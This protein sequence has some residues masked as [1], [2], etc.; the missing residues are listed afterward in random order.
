MLMKASAEN[1]CCCCRE[2]YKTYMQLLRTSMVSSMFC[3]TGACAAARP[4][5]LMRTLP[6]TP[7]RAA[8]PR[9]LNAARPM[10]PYAFRSC[11]SSFLI[12][13]SLLTC[14]RAQGCSISMLL[15]VWHE[16]AQVV[17]AVGI[18]GL[19]LLVLCQTVGTR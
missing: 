2:G 5:R 10:L 12:F 14:R 3:A 16:A 11:C 4:M 6:S 17:K 9:A 18:A 19:T 15:V 7:S 1:D 8:S 13:S